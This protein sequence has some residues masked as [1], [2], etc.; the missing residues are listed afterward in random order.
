[1]S[2][3]LML[4]ILPWR[5]HTLVL[6]RGKLPLGGTILNRLGL[7]VVAALGPV[8]PSI[9]PLFFGLPTLPVGGVPTPSW[10][11]RP[12]PPG[13]ISR[14]QRSALIMPVHTNVGLARPML[15][16]RPLLGGRT[17]RLRLHTML[18]PLLLLLLL[19]LLVVVAVLAV[20]PRLRESG[21][22]GSASLRVW[23]RRA[24]CR[25]L[26]LGLGGRGRPWG[27]GQV[28]HRRWRWRR[29]KEPARR[30]D[31]PVAGMDCLS[32]QG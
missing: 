18:L 29:R 15:M 22:E 13:L 5:P 32:R 3:G 19:P 2:H 23:F 31:V 14:T 26:S 27:L 11:M 1:M 12:V 9:F 7:S 6:R 8:L 30:C 25:R 17:P 16:L 28:G 24:L 10:P 21:T 4:R 20:L